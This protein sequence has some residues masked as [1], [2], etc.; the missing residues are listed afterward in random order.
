MKHDIQHRYLQK[1]IARIHPD[2]L[3]QN[4]S[5]LNYLFITYLNDT[6]TII[7]IVSLQFNSKSVIPYY[8]IN[9][10]YIVRY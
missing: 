2:N 7:I 1:N 3:D 10:T 4:H 8:H 9:T 6:Y 5:V